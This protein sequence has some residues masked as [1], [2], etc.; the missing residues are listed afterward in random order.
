[1]SINRK[2]LKIISTP[3]QC[4]CAGTCEALFWQK[5]TCPYEVKYKS[6]LRVWCQQNSAECC[7]GLTFSH[8]E[9]LV[10]GGKLK[11]TQDVS[12]F[13]VEVLEP[14]HKQGVY[15]CGL[16]SRNGTIIKLA[17][18]YIHNSTASY[19]WSL[20]RW[21]LLPLLP[22]VTTFTRMYLKT[23]KKHLFKVNLNFPYLET[24]QQHEELQVLHLFLVFP[25][26][27]DGLYDD[28]GRAVTEQEYENAESLL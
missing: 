10:D 25:Q 9:R 6:L 3:K 22:I 13:T 4:H 16:L 24:F 11:V 14:N 1:M 5:L 7:T 17:E 18:G 26:K 19:I 8:S 15:W 21:I 28:V 2:H 20:I 12:S 27:A 23:T